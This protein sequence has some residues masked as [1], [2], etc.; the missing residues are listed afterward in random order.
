MRQRD[1][2]AAI[3]VGGHLGDDLGGDIAGGGK[4]VGPLDQRAGDNGA[5]LQHILHVHQITVVHMLGEI[6]GVVEMDNSLIVRLHDV[7]GQQD[8]VGDVAADLA[9]H[10]V[11]LGGVD[12][13]V[14]VGILLLGLLVVALDKT[15]DLV[16]RGVGL[17]HQRA[18]IAVGNVVL[19][20]LESTMSHDLLLHQILYFLHAGGATQLL[21]AEHHA[22]CDALDLDGGHADALIHCVIGL[23]DGDDDLGNIKCGL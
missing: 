19:G 14:L 10:I 22:L 23:A 9:G 4:A 3:L 2:L 21:T 6:V 11:P 8:A 13:R 7:P 5:V 15:E 12:H 1:A 20:D 17:A 16:V 18:G